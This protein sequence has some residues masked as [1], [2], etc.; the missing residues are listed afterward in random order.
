[1]GGQLSCFK[2]PFRRDLK[3]GKDDIRSCDCAGCIS[4]QFR[5]NLAVCRLGDCHHILAGRSLYHHESHASLCGGEFDKMRNVDV[6]SEQ[7]FS[8]H[9]TE[10]IGA[11]CAHESNLAARPGRCYSRVRAPTTTVHVKFGG[12]NTLT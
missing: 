2:Y 9:S 5:R 10:K 3:L 11:V 7:P 8:A 4:H 12:K 6:F 1:M